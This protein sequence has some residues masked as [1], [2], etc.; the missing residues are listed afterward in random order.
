MPIR[1]NLPTE[2][3]SHRVTQTQENIVEPYIGLTAKTFKER[4]NGH[5]SNFRTEAKKKAT[6]LSSHIWK[7]I[8]EEK[9]YHITWKFV[10]QAKP[11]SPVSGVC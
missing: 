11:F 1:W 6:K 9:E 10:S 5:N 2:K 7:L 4:W 3:R 8:D